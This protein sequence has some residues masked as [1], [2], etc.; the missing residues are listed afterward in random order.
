[1]ALPVEMVKL[2]KT[3]DANY[4]RTQ[5]AVGQNVSRPPFSPSFSSPASSSSFQQLCHLLA[6]EL[7]SPLNFLF[8]RP[9]KIL[10]LKAQLATITDLLPGTSSSTPSS[11][12]N[13]AAGL[14]SDSED[15]EN[16][17]D[18]ELNEAEQATLRAVGLLEAEKKKSKGKGKARATPRKIIFKETKEEGM[19]EF[20]LSR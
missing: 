4:V 3:Q 11:S 15:D 1:V 12:S 16:M 19:L 20:S 14:G 17:S 2:L 10:R 9:Q 8:R 7:T 18:N 5:R 13:P 6:S